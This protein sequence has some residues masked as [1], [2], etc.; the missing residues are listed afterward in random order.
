M[1]DSENYK[2]N[3]RVTADFMFYDTPINTT[4]TITKISDTSPVKFEVTFDNPVKLDAKIS[5]TIVA[6][7]VNR[8]SEIPEWLMNDVINTKSPSLTSM[9]LYNSSINPIDIV[10]NRGGR[11]RRTRRRTQRRSK[12]RRQRKS[13]RRRRHSRE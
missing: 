5:Q 3:D 8:N 1:D 12:H 10:P 2:V 11:K 6:D 13:H 7:Y 4:G 9:W